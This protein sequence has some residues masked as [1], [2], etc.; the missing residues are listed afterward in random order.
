HSGLI[1]PVGTGIGRIKA[2]HQ[3]AERY[4][5]FA[6]STFAQKVS[7]AN[8]RLVVDTANGAAFETTPLALSRLG[9]NFS[10]ENAAPN[11]FNINESCG[12]THP[13]NISKLV[14]SK[15]ADAGI[16]HDG[17]ADRV[18]FC[19]ET[20]D[21]L[22]GDELLAIIA[23][24]RLSRA[25]GKERGV[26]ATIMS[27]LGLDYLIASHGGHVVRTAVG[28]RSVMDAMIKHELTLGGEQSGHIILRDKTTTGDGLITAI[29][30]LGIMA[31]SGKPLSELRKV[32]SK[33]PQVQR[34]IRVREK[35]SF[36]EFPEL[37]AALE[38]E[39]VRLG[40]RGRI[41][42]RYSGTE[43]KARL[44]LEG[45]DKRELIQSADILSAFIVRHL[46]P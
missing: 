24:D 14:R 23:I 22:D 32:L 27:N 8:L 44:L 4:S 16:A 39:E 5:L 2:G 18:L 17:D 1:P 15:R 6:V 38:A 20:G 25:E 30:I 45:P 26:A 3:G 42:L 21:L 41:L 40:Q 36:A 33:F 10:L 28:D 35:R 31:K 13:E 29:E 11:G 7:L 37:I 9:A 34:D 19:D 43:S 12:S 46:G